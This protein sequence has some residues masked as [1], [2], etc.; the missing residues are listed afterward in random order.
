MT[1][2][3]DRGLARRLERTEGSLGASFTRV[4]QAAERGSTWQ[5]F[6]GTYAIFD[7]ADSPL[8][9]SFGLGVF[10]PATP[11]LL[12]GLEAFFWSRGA[13][14]MHEV[15]P[16]AG[17]ATTALLVDRGYRPIEMSSVLVQ[18]IDQLAA[19]AAASGLRARPIDAS[20]HA[21]WMDTMAAGWANDATFAAPLRPLAER[22]CANREM[23]HYAVERAGELIAT[24]SLAI[25]EGIA[26]LAGASTVPQAR[27][28]GAQGLLLAARLADAQRRGCEL[29][30]IV[31]EPGSTSQRNVERRGFRVAYT[32]TKWCATAQPS[33]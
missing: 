28:Q 10:E 14:A 27:G 16:L 30:M 26:L 32:R 1:W 9:Q 31:T 8:T 20:D 23:M 29:A 4:P 5:D 21:A 15:S 12:D 3:M 7:G 6:A 22:L 13:P 24:A 33:A 11:E 2:F 19:P 25:H 17:V 18:A